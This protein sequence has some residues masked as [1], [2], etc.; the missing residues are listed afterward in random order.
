MRVWNGA[1]VSS[2]CLLKTSVIFLDENT[3]NLQKQN[4][5]I[6]AIILIYSYK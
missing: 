1:L 6:E 5:M 2:K 4:D 3:F